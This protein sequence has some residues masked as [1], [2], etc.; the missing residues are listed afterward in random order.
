LQ[1]FATDRDF[2]NSV[3]IIRRY[4]INLSCGDLP[5][6]MAAAQT[7]FVGGFMSISL[8]QITV[9]CLFLLLAD[10]TLTTEVEQDKLYGGICVEALDEPARPETGEP[11]AGNMLDLDGDV[12]FVKGLLRCDLSQGFA[13]DLPRPL[14]DDAEWINAPADVTSSPNADLAGG[15]NRSD[16]R[17]ALF[18]SGA[19][20]EDRGELYTA[21]L[22]FETDFWG[23]SSVAFQPFGGVGVG[24]DDT[25]GVFGLDIILKYPILSGGGTTVNVEGGGG[26]QQAGPDSWPDD[27]THFNFRTN[28]GVGVEID[29][30]GGQS[31]LFGGR[32]LHV[33]NA[34]IDDQ[35]NPGVN[36][37]MVYAGWGFRF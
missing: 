32:W 21:H 20:G 4:P 30:G 13:L 3:R 33:S 24:R 34:H 9:V 17:T 14:C 11:A 6:G 22:S 7:H 27:G 1:V 25:T 19:F 35:Q 2:L 31:W 18:F 37:I 29:A 15:Y 36:E 10:V 26:V 8:R 23:A 12:S 5:L 16:W 28:L